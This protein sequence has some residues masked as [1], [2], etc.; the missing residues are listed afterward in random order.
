[1]ELKLSA[2][3]EHA[4]VTQDNKLNIIGILDSIQALAFPVVLPVLMVVLVMEMKKTQLGDQQNITVKMADEDGNV[5]FSLSGG[6]QAQSRTP[7]IPPNAPPP[8]VNQIIRLQNIQFPKPGTYAVDVLI[9][10][11]PAGHLPL[12]VTQTPVAQISEGGTPPTS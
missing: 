5:M 3:A 12:H 6:L 8:K 2:L 9:N 11:H 7:V 1:M 10:N 4:N